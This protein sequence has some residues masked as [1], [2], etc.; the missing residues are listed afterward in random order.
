MMPPP[1]LPKTN[2]AASPR[3]WRH[4][5]LSALLA[6]ACSALLPHRA[7]ADSV[8]CPDAQLLGPALI[9]S[10][11]W[12]C[13]FPIRLA[14]ATLAQGGGDIPDKAADQPLCICTDTFDVPHGGL[15]YGMWEPARLIELVRTPGCSPA[16][17]GI[18]LEA[19]GNLQRGSRG[20]M[21][22]DQGD[23]AFYH[24][25]LWAF[26]LLAMLELFTP[27]QCQRD[28]GIDMDLLYFSELDPTWIYDEL[29]FFANPE[30]AAV[31][32]ATAQAACVADAVAATAGKPIDELFWCA[33]SWGHLYPLS[34]SHLTHTSMPR[35][36]SLLATRSLAAMHRRGLARRTMG[37]DALCEA[38]IEP[39]LPKTQYQLS[40]VYPV[41]EADNRHAIGESTFRWG[42]DRAL[43]GVGEDYLHLVWRWLDCCLTF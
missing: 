42:E 9:S 23:R 40:L 14:G 7:Q 43:P 37:E 34:G 26:P 36:T 25:H 20:G 16:L 19:T 18:K 6:T 13:V 39:F 30:A 35:N 27:E 8:D 5:L 12:D 11:C 38:Q 24:Y 22:Y 17:G 3:G 4:I 31:A 41:A 28:A 21:L 32:S 2:K 10:I 29:A 33:G 1:R 15:T